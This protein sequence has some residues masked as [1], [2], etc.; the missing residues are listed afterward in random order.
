MLQGDFIANDALASNTVLQDAPSGEWTATTQDRHD[1]ASTPTASRPACV[2]W[3]SREPEHVLQDRRDPVDAAATPVRAHRHPE[4]RG[5]PADL[6]RA[7]RPPRAARCRPPCCCAPATTGTN[8]IGEFSTDDGAT[9]VRDRP[10]A[11]T[12]RRSPVRCKVGPRGLP[13]RERWRQRHVRLLRLNGG[14][15]DTT[16][17]DLLGAAAPRC[18]TSSTARRSTRSGQIVNPSAANPPTV[19]RRP[20]DAA[21]R[22]AATSTATAATPRCPAAGRCRRARGWRRRRSRTPTSTATARRPG[23]ALINSLNPNHFA[24]D[25]AAVQGRHRP[26]H[27]RRPARQVGGAGADR[28]RQRRHAAA[29]DGA[30]AQLGRAAT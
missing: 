3:K 20:P 8:I 13:R 18:R 19:G 29:G 9:W 7:S 27:G 30:V 24:Q 21:D 11:P 14:S 10:R 16:A 23:L 25:G 15:A 5:Q 17:G 4:R 12:R 2:I 28:Q 26:G 1:R 22:S 6:A